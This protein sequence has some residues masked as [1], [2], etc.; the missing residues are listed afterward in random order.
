[1][2]RRCAS[3][4]LT[5]LV[6]LPIVQL[7]C[8]IACASEDSVTVSGECHHHRA[9]ASS[10][11]SVVTAEQHDCGEHATPSAAIDAIR[12][13]DLDAVRVVATTVIVPLVAD[14]AHLPGASS[15][16]PGDPPTGLLVLLR[17]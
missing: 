7:R 1:M 2:R 10:C 3:L 11:I 4:L 16:P 15:S 14:L 5:V 6:S 9:T 13:A 12:G 17:V 8:A